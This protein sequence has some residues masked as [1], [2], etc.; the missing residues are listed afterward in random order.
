MSR[1][2]GITVGIRESTQNSN[3]DRSTKT[4]LQ[5]REVRRT[6]MSEKMYRLGSFF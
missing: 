4:E 5:L 2:I 3:F 1:R 6:Y